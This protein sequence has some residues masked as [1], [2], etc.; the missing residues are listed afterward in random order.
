MLALPHP[1]H[2]RNADWFRPALPQ[3][4]GYPYKRIALRATLVAV[5]ATSAGHTA[6]AL[7]GAG[8]GNQ[9]LKSTSYEGLTR[10]DIFQLVRSKPEIDHK[11]SIR[12]KSFA[13][14]KATGISASETFLQFGVLRISD[15][16]SN[17]TAQEMSLLLAVG[18]QNDFSLFPPL[19]RGCA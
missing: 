7:C 9:E 5:A 13:F 1:R 17:K 18:P 3:A 11:L 8:T 16:N 2:E 10:Q 12:S 15:I 19:T 14:A 4:L 6:G